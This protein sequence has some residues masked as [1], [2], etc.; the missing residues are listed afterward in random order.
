M[1]IELGEIPELTRKMPTE[2]ILEF[3][4]SRRAVEIALHMID[5]V[6]M[7]YTQKLI[8]KL[9]DDRSGTCV[10]GIA[11]DVVRVEEKLMDTLKIG[12]CEAY[13]ECHMKVAQ[14]NECVDSL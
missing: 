1:L 10:S 9:H 7:P 12:Q 4:I 8:A 6:Y 3:K 2:Q 14:F 11:N 5:A 13:R